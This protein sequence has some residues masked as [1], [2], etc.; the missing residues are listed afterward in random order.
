[1]KKIIFLALAIS[2]FSYA[3][4][5]PKHVLLPADYQANWIHY[6]TGNRSNGKQV[7]VY[8]ANEIAVNSAISGK[9]ADGSIV[10]MEIYKTLPNTDGK[11]TVNDNGVFKKGAFA[12]IGVMEKRSDWSANYS[13]DKRAGDWGF[14]L[15]KAD[16]SVKDNNLDCAS[17]HLPL[18]AQDYLFSHHSLVGHGE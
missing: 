15:Y 8:Y 3:G 4:G 10:I 17:C 1:M 16:G 11:P 9:Y 7:A 13:A 5:N 18:S 12:A 14:A 2:G 6:K